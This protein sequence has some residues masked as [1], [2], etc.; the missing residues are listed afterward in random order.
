MILKSRFRLLLFLVVMGLLSVFSGITMAATTVKGEW[1]DYT[2]SAEGFALALPIGWTSLDLDP[3]TIETSIKKVT[4]EN[5]EL[6][7]IINQAEGMIAQGV[8]FFAFEFNNTQ[9]AAFPTSINV[10][11][12]E[13]PNKP[14]LDEMAKLTT[15]Q[16]EKMSN[17]EKKPTH[18]RIKIK[19]GE[20]EEFSYTMKVKSGKQTIAVSFS[21]YVIV[22]QNDLFII[23]L[24]TIQNQAAKYA[25]TFK[26]IIESFQL[27]EKTVAVEVDAN[28]E[29][30]IS[31]DE[32]EIGT[33]EATDEA[34][35][36]D[37]ADAAD[38]EEAA[39]DEA[40]V[41]DEAD[42]E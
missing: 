33:A 1:K 18:R 26:Q 37:E 19:A 11:R 13:L 2:V 31:A 7:A 36:V 4:K 32:A 34:V 12:Q 22:N 6:G 28:Q 21:Q 25:P 38:A 23:T 9:S 27:V 10:I 39:V 8:K 20:A 30:S 16:L 17:L 14:S 29:E 41:I 35:V 3:E 42:E 24:A 40:E 5:P 15:K